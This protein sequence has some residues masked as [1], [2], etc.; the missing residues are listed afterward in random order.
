[1]IT[2]DFL[3]YSSHKTSTQTLVS[4]LKLNNSKNEIFKVLL[5]KG[6]PYQIIKDKLKID[7]EKNNKINYF[8]K[9]NLRTAK[10]IHSNKLE[11][12]T[13]KNFLS[14]KE[15]EKIIIWPV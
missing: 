3:V 7:Y 11:I 1:M 5:N 12:Y 15:C 10:K 13:I 8:N 14:I 6:Y 4:T 2:L 9:I